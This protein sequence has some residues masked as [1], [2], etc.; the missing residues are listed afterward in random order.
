VQ[1]TGSTWRDLK[2]GRGTVDPGRAS[3]AACCAP[4][5]GGCRG[6]NPRELDSAGQRP[7][8]AQRSYG[9]GAGRKWRRVP[10]LAPGQRPR[11]ALERP[12]A[13]WGV[14]A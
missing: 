11:G 1:V 8:Y 7:R 10:R 14:G 13:H 5:R 6:N 9:D 2:L 3:A 12:R 4:C